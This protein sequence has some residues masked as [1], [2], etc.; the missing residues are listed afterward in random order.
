MS[1][2]ALLTRL[3]ELEQ[4]VDFWLDCLQEIQGPASTEA[5]ILRHGLSTMSQLLCVRRAI[6]RHDYTSEEEAARTLRESVLMVE[7]FDTKLRE[8]TRE[9]AAELVDQEIPC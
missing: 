2:E 4:R 3:D 1:K 8:A 6:M 5:S 7:R 9:S